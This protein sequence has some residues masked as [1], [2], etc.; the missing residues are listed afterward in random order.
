MKS[1]LEIAGLICAVCLCA[2]ALSWSANDL[3][4]FGDNA[5][6]SDASP[7]GYVRGEPIYEQL[8]RDNESLTC[9]YRYSTLFCGNLEYGGRRRCT[10]HPG[11]NISL[12]IGNPYTHE[13]HVIDGCPTYVAVGT[14]DCLPGVDPRP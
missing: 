5:E 12:P 11:D 7:D 10:S 8:R 6:E 1:H 14:E 4:I 2:G 13:L 3:T 9:C